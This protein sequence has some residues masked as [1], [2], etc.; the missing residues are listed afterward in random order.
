MKRYFNTQYLTT[1]LLLVPVLL[2]AITIG[3]ELGWGR[4]IGWKLKEKLQLQAQ[5][6]RLQ[7]NKAA[8]APLQPEFGLPPLDQAYTE[9][10]ERP[11]FVPTRRTS[12]ALPGEGKTA[13]QKGQYLLTGVILTN[14]KNIALLREI[15]S[16]KML[17]VEQ[18]AELNGMQVEK[19][20]A[21]KIIFKQGTDRE[22]VVLKIPPMSKTPPPTTQVVTT[23]LPGMSAAPAV[24]AL[25]APAITAPAVPPAP[26]RLPG[27]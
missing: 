13:M 10:V 22:E 19:L 7:G 2:L 23:N 11:L 15:A 9:I 27:S 5:A 17:R 12:P 18:G 4:G 24:P 1:L 25:P 20:E 8:V 26:A 21:E 3:T 6:P 14:G 16:G